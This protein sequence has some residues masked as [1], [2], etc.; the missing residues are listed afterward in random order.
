MKYP[1]PCQMKKLV[2]AHIKPANDLRD[3]PGVN[4]RV[5][6]VHRSDASWVIEGTVGDRAPIH[7]VRI[8]TPSPDGSHERVEL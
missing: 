5:K 7:R 4:R 2:S 8:V 3:R 6:Y 1:L